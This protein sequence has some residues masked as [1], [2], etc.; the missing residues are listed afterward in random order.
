[1]G[2]DSISSFRSKVATMEVE[3]KAWERASENTSRSHSAA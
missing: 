3:V 2:S 1:V